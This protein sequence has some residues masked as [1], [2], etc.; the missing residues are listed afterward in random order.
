MVFFRTDM[1]SMDQ[2]GAWAATPE[3]VLV[4]AAAAAAQ[5]SCE[6]DLA[7]GLARAAKAEYLADLAVAKGVGPTVPHKMGGHNLREQVVQGAE[8]DAAAAE[9]E[10]ERM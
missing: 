4:E 7:L 9:E 3:A 2:F 8:V 6:V 10:G 5:A 1:D